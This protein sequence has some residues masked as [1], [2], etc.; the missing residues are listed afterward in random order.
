MTTTT[1]KIFSYNNGIVQGL[2]PTFDGIYN[3]ETQEIDRFTNANH[4][5]KSNATEINL[6]AEINGTLIAVNNVPT[7]I[8]PYAISKDDGVTWEFKS[9]DMSK[10]GRFVNMYSENGKL[11][12]QREL[13]GVT[14]ISETTD[15][16]TWVDRY[17]IPAINLA[18]VDNG[19]NVVAVSQ[20]TSYKSTDGGKTFSTKANPALLK[21]PYVK[22]NQFVSW[23][24]DNMVYSRDGVNW[25]T[26][27]GGIGII[28]VYIDKENDR[29][30]GMNKDFVYLS[31]DG[32]KWTALDDNIDTKLEHIY[33]SPPNV[34][35][36]TVENKKIIKTLNDDLPLGKM[37][38]DTNRDH[39]MFHY[40]EQ[41]KVPL[42]KMKVNHVNRINWTDIYIRSNNRL[43]YG[44]RNYGGISAFKPVEYAN[45]INYVGTGRSTKGL[46]VS[47]TKLL[48]DGRIMATHSQ[49]YN[50]ITKGVAFF[51]ESDFTDG[52]DQKTVEPIL[53]V[54]L[55]FTPGIYIPYQIVEVGNGTIGVIARGTDTKNQPSTILYTSKD[56]GKTWETSSPMKGTIN[57]HVVANG[58]IYLFGAMS[59]QSSNPVIH[60]SE[61]DGKTFTEIN[62]FKGINEN[63]S[64]NNPGG[65]GAV[66]YRD[67]VF[68]WN[69][70]VPYISTDLVNWKR[71]FPVGNMISGVQEGD[72]VYDPINDWFLLS[73]SNYLGVSRDGENWRELMVHHAMPAKIGDKN[74]F[75]REVTISSDEISK[76]GMPKAPWQGGSSTEKD[77]SAPTANIE[78]AS[79]DW[80][81]RHATIEVS[82]VED[83]GEGFDYM[84][85]PDG[86]ISKESNISFVV[87]ENGSYSFKL[88]D[89]AGNMKE[90]IMDVTTIDKT[91]AT[92]EVE[93]S[94][95]NWTK[96]SVGLNLKATDTE[97][98]IS[99]IE[100][101]NGERVDSNTFTYEAVDNGDYLFKAV[102]NAG[103]T[104]EH[105]VT[106][107]NID[108]EAPQVQATAS[109]EEWTQESVTLNISAKDALSGVSHI[110]L[111]N[112]E[113]VSNDTTEYTVSKNGEYI[114]HAVDAVGNKTEY[115]YE[116]N[117]IDNT[118]ATAVVES[119]I[120]SPT[121]EDVVLSI[122]ASDE[123]SG[124]ASIT[125]PSGEIVERDT[126]EVKATENGVYTFIVKDKA[127]N[128]STVTHEVK[129][130]D[131]EP[132]ETTLT[133]LTSGWTNEFSA[134]EVQASDKG[135]GVDYI[136]TPDGDKV[137]ADKFV[138]EASENGVYTFTTV[139]KAGNEWT[140]SISVTNIDRTV[141]TAKVTPSTTKS[142]NAKFGVTLSIE[143]KDAQ[144]GV[145]FI[146][147]PNGV[148]I[149]GDTANYHVH[150]NGEYTF[151]VL[152]R[153]GNAWTVTQEV[154]NLKGNA[155]RAKQDPTGEVIYLPNGKVWK[156]K[157]PN[158]PKG[159]IG[160]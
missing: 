115:R 45:H 60:V 113:K 152:D 32:E 156:G 110:E 34:P 26:A 126:A 18:I 136:V 89:K 24:T 2:K 143:A 157:A 97:S 128:E 83:E 154:K 56:E 57:E 48:S 130:I 29:F 20:T 119:D 153:A 62:Q 131:R 122:K 78:V 148:V 47:D 99:Y 46:Y 108:K 75:Y 155:Y 42:G 1:G 107:K 49:S 129:N 93:V 146:I 147:L 23:T 137:E 53:H 145:E 19:E 17:S 4:P 37:F 121:K 85:L 140:E 65:R 12:G 138:F 144:S 114:F 55:P 160:R 142:T 31:K 100:L 106:I 158:P 38:W 159:L 120:T 109:T 82:G 41:P 8:Y 84:S 6:M 134:I 9:R 102:D 94:T 133:N 81:N 61:D 69:Y 95:D 66:A 25:E 72:V 124:V 135:S 105:I 74:F 101:P 21:K 58:K 40:Y 71:V 90:Y 51:K 10:Y 70:R 151:V 118:P 125:L 67:G 63:Y 33:F 87:T 116:V 64:W 35:N 73:S 141:G 52:D 98:G 86:T 92:V 103:N 68:V 16:L 132:G 111:P 7:T 27:E 117:N 112:G 30:I 139:D 123:E 43:I 88:Y 14:Y 15:G 79:K 127:G 104:K 76:N 149:S 150:A 13:N 22:G 3:P 44:Y 50:G 5:F 28:R 80:T 11:V 59:S 36:R 54:S 39:Y 91:P 77:E 96:E